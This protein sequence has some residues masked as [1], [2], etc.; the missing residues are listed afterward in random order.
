MQRRQSAPN[1]GGALGDGP[2]GLWRRRG[3]AVFGPVATIDRYA[4]FAEALRM[5]EERFVT[6][7]G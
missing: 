2:R 4:D 3:F 1:S 7:Q 6:L 5:T